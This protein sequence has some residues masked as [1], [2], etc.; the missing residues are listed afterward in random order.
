M[1]VHSLISDPY[2]TDSN[3]TS[4]NHW[5]SVIIK[6]NPKE[7]LMTDTTYQGWT[8][9]ETYNV[10][11]YIN[12]DYGLYELAKDTVR[13]GGTYG[14]FCEIMKRCYNSYKTPDGVSWTDTKIDG[15]EI[16]EMMQW[17]VA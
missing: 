17:L 4:L 11:L 3:R 13:D 15:M 10:A 5:F 7:N 1:R 12:N 14:E 2:V 9:Y 16:N 6:R 8:N